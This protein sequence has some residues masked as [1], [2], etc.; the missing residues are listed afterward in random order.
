MHLPRDRV[1]RRQG[2]AVTL[3]EGGAPSPLRGG[4]RRPSPR[5]L[6]LHPGQRR[7]DR[8]PSSAP[9]RRGALGRL[10][11]LRRRRGPRAPRPASRCSNRARRPPSARRARA[12]RRAPGPRS[13]G[14]GRRRVR[15]AGRSAARAAPAAP[16][17]APRH[18]RRAR[19]APRGWPRDPGPV[20][21]R[22]R[23][24]AGVRG[25]HPCTTDSGG[26][27]TRG[28]TGQ[29]DLVPVVQGPHRQPELRSGLADRQPVSCHVVHHADKAAPSRRVRVKPSVTRTGD[30]TRTGGSGRHRPV[31]GAEP[32][33]VTTPG[34]D[35]A[36]RASG[37]GRWY[38]SGMSS[39][40]AS[41]SSSCSSCL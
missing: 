30:V 15:G 1:E 34:A 38:T 4:C 31:P 9:A 40:S 2:L 36:Q 19:R 25:R 20:R 14:R 11:P 21:G 6:G 12:G 7:R 35:A 41:T 10:L 16:A 22:R 28:R 24:G 27:R 26:G 32:V 5:Q 23:C 39:P 29:P 17:T 18:R 3:D 13:C 37:S 8:R 33:L